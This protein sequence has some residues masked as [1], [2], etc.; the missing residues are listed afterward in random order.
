VTQIRIL[1]FLPDFAGQAGG[2]RIWRAATF[3]V[4]LALSLLAV[5]LLA[6]AQEPGK[7]PHIGYLVS[8]AAPGPNDEAFRQGLR[9][10]GYLEGQNVAMEWRWAGGNPDRLPGLAADLVRRRVDLIVAG[11][12]QAVRAATQ[13]TRTTPIVVA[14]AE[15]LVESGF[16]AS[17]AHPGGNLT[18]LTLLSAELAGKRLELLK[19]ALPGVSRVAVLWDATSTSAEVRTTEA[20]ARSLG[21][22][23]HLLEVRGPSEFSRAIEAAIRGHADALTVLTSSFLTTNRKPLLDL[24]AKS[25]LPTMYSFREYVVEGGLLSYGPS[26]PD[27]YRR[28]ASYVDKILKGAS[29]GD[30]PIEQPTTYELVINLK[31]AK[32]LGLTIPQSVLLRADEVIQ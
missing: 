29:P 5:P 4:V 28:A 27:L 7:K 13:A 22:Q 11:G 31:T 25:R 19:E 32:A 17:L 12:T 30:L 20:A 15:D 16:V 9:A 21:L 18:G 8:R 1:N 2:L 26:I 10:L 14:A 3:I 6:S 23:L 24:T